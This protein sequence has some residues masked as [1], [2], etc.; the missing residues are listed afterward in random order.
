MPDQRQLPTTATVRLDSGMI[1]GVYDDGVWQFLGVPYA[2][3]LVGKA[4]FAYPAEAS[5]S[6]IRNCRR[7]GDIAFQTAT[8]GHVGRSVVSQL[9]QGPECL[10]L[11]VRVDA[12]HPGEKKPVLVWFHGGGLFA[13]SNAEPNI[14]TAAFAREG[15]VEVTANSRLGIFGYFDFGDGSDP[16]RG[17]LDQVAALK[18]VQRNIHLFGGDPAN[19]TIAGHSAGGFSAA[20]L[21]VSPASQGLF[22]KVFLGSGASSARHPRSTAEMVRRVVVDSADV[23]SP[24][25]LTEMTTERLLDVQARGIEECY[26]QM[27]P[28]YGR[29]SV[30]GLPFEHTIA[31]G[32]VVTD[33]PESLSG[34][35][36]PDVP[37]MIGTT[38][39]E[40]VFH[41]SQFAEN[42]SSADAAAAYEGMVRPLGLSGREV[43]HAYSTMMPSARPRDLLAT[44]NADLRFNLDSLRMARAQQRFA[45]TYR[46]VIGTFDEHGVGTT[47]HGAVQGH[48]WR[49]STGRPVAL[50]PKQVPFNDQTAQFVHSAVTSFVMTGAPRSQTLQAGD[51]SYSWP[52]ASTADEVMLVTPIGHD[53][54]HDSVADRLAWWDQAAH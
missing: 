48:A 8:G 31:A 53:I 30:L 14:T 36:R 41:V 49:Q 35:A 11:N 46:F 1:R 9:R 21:M 38:T 43:V 32:T 3:S 40:C 15:I 19:V 45:P 50:K 2:A 4:R 20:E 47:P 18:W 7:F 25:Q 54:V 29:A 42:L 6:G 27:P 28:Q 12:L 52:K 34:G 37:L 44:I 13:G 10:N 26:T 17:L 33:V 24:A 16:N 51:S 23:R 39:G 22:T 5:W